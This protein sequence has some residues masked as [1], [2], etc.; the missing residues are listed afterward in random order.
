M[1][2]GI[3]DVMCFVY[4]DEVSNNYE[5]YIKHMTIPSRPIVGGGGGGVTWQ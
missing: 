3:S 4:T 2:V 1:D 5:I